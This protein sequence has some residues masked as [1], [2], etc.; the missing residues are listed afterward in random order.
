[1]IAYE[2]IN[3]FRYYNWK[4]ERNTLTIYYLLTI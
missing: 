2:N 3:N 4:Q 1:M